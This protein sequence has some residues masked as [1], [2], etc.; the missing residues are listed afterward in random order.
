[1]TANDLLKAGDEVAAL[2][3]INAVRKPDDLHLRRA[4]EEA[5]QQRQRFGT[6][7]RVGFRLEL[8]K[9]HTRGVCNL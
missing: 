8:F 4:G 9:L 6:I 2:A 7:D 3:E 5:S 1:M